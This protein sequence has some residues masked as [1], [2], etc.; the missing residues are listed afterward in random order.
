MPEESEPR[1]RGIWILHKI[2]ADLQSARMWP[3]RLAHLKHQDALCSLFL[4][5][6]VCL[7]PRSK[8]QGPHG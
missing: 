4:W 2:N 1:L 3:V 7:S 6:V 5:A 8:L